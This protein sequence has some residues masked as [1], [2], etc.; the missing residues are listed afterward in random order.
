ML[1]SGVQYVVVV[2]MAGVDSVR[3]R[4]LEGD[5]LAVGVGYPGFNFLVGSGHGYFVYRQ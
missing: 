2:V 5:A 3:L 4:A 1:E